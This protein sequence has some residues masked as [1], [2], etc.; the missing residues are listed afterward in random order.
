MQS[1]SQRDRRQSTVDGV[2]VVVRRSRHIHGDDQMRRWMYGQGGDAC[3]GAFVGVLA[4]VFSSAV[5]HVDAGSSGM[6][7]VHDSFEITAAF[8]PHADHIGQPA[9]RKKQSENTCGREQGEKMRERS[10]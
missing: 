3:F 8:H 2:G 7:N 4:G 6:D 10:V 1:S 5:C 9:E